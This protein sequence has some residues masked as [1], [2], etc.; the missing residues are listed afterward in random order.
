MTVLRIY[1]EDQPE[2][3]QTL[4]DP[5][6]ISGALE[7]V[8]VTYARWPCEVAPDPMAEPDD[9][10]KAYADPV[11][12]L[13]RTHGFRSQDVIRMTPDHPQ[14]LEL[15]QKFLDEHRHQEFEI[16]FFVEGRGLF[17]LHPGRQV[18]AVLC[19]A[20]DLLSVPEGM[21]H[22]FDMGER[23]QFTCLR[24]FT[25]PEGWIAELTGDPIARRFPDLH[26]FLEQP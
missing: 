20:G 2:C 21:P 17:F 10:F 26:A 7:A 3:W 1:P 22:W 15:R 9:L 16:R 18:F 23:P 12:A 25:R 5:T 6:E 11:N 24:F 13:R 4:S 19:E 14:R 8:G